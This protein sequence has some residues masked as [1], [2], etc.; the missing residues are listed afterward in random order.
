MHSTDDT[1][2]TLFLA[3]EAGTLA[4]GGRLAAALVPGLVIFL[5]GDLGAGKTTLTRGILRGLGFEGRVKSPTYTLVEPYTVSNLYLY[6]FDLYRFS[7]PSEW[8]DAGFRDY[9]NRD[10]VCLI[11]WA[12]KAEGLLPAPDWLIQLAP[13]AEGRRLTLTAKT[14]NGTQCLARLIR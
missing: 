7:D 6:H 1:A 12:D 8:E 3:D 9:F 5:E 10:S 4:M 14:K 2:F 13:E 11:E